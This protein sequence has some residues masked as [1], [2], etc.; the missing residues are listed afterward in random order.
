MVRLEYGLDFDA[1]LEY[2]RE[3]YRSIWELGS[4]GRRK[5]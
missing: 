2:V 5:D 3:E 4:S 1:A